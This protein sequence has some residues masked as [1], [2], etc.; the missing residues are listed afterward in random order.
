[1]TGQRTRRQDPTPF[2][3]GARFKVAAGL[4]DHVV[5]DARHAQTITE[6]PYVLGVVATRGSSVMVN[7]VHGNDQLALAGE[8][9]QSE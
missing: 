8:H 2:G 3:P 4:D 6:S 9:Q 5:N 1:V 7:V